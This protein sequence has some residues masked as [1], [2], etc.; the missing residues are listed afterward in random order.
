M[1]SSVNRGVLRQDTVVSISHRS[2]RIYPA[3]NQSSGK[4]TSPTSD[5]KY[6]K[7]GWSSS[8]ESRYRVLPRPTIFV[9]CIR[10]IIHSSGDS[11]K[12]LRGGDQR[13]KIWD[14]NS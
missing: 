14:I 12:L 4:S 6:N 5:S 7:V 13:L 11:S 8:I 2:V 10:S 9:P 1:C 3:G